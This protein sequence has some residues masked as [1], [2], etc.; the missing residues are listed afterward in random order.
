MNKNDKDIWF[1]AMKYGVG[2]GLPVTWQGWIVFLI[3]IVLVII[4]ALFITRSPWL[5]ILFIIYVFVLTGI[6]LFICWKKGEKPE[7]RWGKKL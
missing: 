6:L 5:V 4:G 7:L 1:P 2:W 3:Y